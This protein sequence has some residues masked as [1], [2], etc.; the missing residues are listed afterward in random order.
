MIDRRR[1]LLT[2]AILVGGGAAGYFGTPKKPELPVGGPFSVESAS[3]PV[4]LDTLRGRVGLVYFG[5]ASCPDVCPVSLG[6][7]AG[8]LE[9]LTDEERAKVAVLFVS[10]DPERDTPASL[11]AYAAH[12][13]P[14]ILGATGPDATL[15]DF[16]TRYGVTYRKHGVE[17]A[18]GY[19]VDHTSQVV[20][21][22]P[23]GGVREVLPHATPSADIVAAIRRYVGSAKA[24]A[25]AAK[26]ADTVKIVDPH[27]RALP[28]GA[29]VTAAYF[30]VENPGP[31]PQALVRAASP[32]AGS[33]ELHAVL[34]ENGMTS[35]RPVERF[36][37]PAGGKVALEPSGNHV[38]LI[39]VTQPV[40]K[41]GTVPLTLTFADGSELAL[42]VPVR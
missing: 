41:G 24:P 9:D 18:L 16:A 21:I 10:L 34:T 2:L 37:V 14:S 6:L 15:R 25:P 19:V 22:A 31:T 17:S 1:V 26:A 5:F 28:P 20:V 35:M 33:V 27:V 13:H 23:D 36:D 29:S 11:A 3:G 4:T 30:V 12:F 42:D 39:G 40:D 32:V 7:V 38:M 8:A